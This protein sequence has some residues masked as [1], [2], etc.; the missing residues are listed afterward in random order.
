MG[1]LISL[2]DGRAVEVEVGGHHR[3]G[4]ATG[5]G[6]SADFDSVEREGTQY[7]VGHGPDVVCWDEPAALR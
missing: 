7:F 2:V 6:V 1:L 4:R 5:D 3:L